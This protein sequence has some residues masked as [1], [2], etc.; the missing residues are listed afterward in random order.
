[1]TTTVLDDAAVRTAV[2]SVSDP[3]FPGVS[4]D[5]LGM[6]EAVVCAGANV[7][8]DLVP[9]FLGCPALDTIKADV[10]AAVTAVD[11]VGGVEV[12]FVNA[13]VW[14]PERVSD[15]GR[16]KLAADF[17]VAVRIGTEV[18]CPVCGHTGVAERSP[19]GPTACRSVAYCENCRNPVE[20][21]RQ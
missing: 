9:T 1:M 16:V 6:V 7:V 14:T 3:E 20:V 13:P 17:T 10:T 4:I 19:F 18:T 8:V 11:G 2:G 5:E 21:M 15:T 12:R